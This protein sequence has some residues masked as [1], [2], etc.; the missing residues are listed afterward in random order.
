MIIRA[1]C[2][3]EINL[4]GWYWGFGSNLQ[5]NKNYH[6]RLK[7][8]QNRGKRLV[9]SL[10]QDNQYQKISDLK[11]IPSQFKTIKTGN[12]QNRVA[13][14]RLNDVKNIITIAF[15]ANFNQFKGSINPRFSLSNYRHSRN[16]VTSDR[17]V[18]GNDAKIKRLA[19]QIVKKENNLARIIKNAYDFTLEYLKYGNPTEGLYSYKQA[20][21]ER[22]TD[23]GG[24]STF[25][26]SVLQSVGIPSRLVVGYL[27]KENLFTKFFSRFD[28]CN[29]SFDFLLMHA[30][31]EVLL[32]DNTW[33]PLDPSIEWR[34][35]HGLTKRL[36]GF[37]FIP[38][39]RLVMSYGQ[40]FKL[41]ISN[42]TYTID[43]FQNPVYV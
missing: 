21:E 35:T 22:I 14:F 36:G 3:S 40:D 27:I 34:R 15:E 41:K 5:M 20:I 12:W 6:F 1:H 9:F 7:F 17:F 43:I 33:F 8:T 32:P 38:P 26:T 24:F 23:C 30:W 4:T 19:K 29:L 39:D 2:Q 37:G 42:K 16:L 13:L 28:F 31:L 18:N 11:I 10:P 25:L